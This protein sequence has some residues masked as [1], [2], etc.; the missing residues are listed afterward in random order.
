MI[1]TV[2]KYGVT[3]QE[4]VKR[5][6][7]QSTEKASLLHLLSEEKYS[8]LYLAFVK[9][10]LK[11]AILAWENKFH[12][13]YLKFQLLLDSDRAYTNIGSQLLNILDHLDHNKRGYKTSLLETE[14]K[15]IQLYRE[16][17]FT[18]LRKTFMPSLHLHKS[19]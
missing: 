16:H 11:G 17:H 13:Q 3:D 12:P 18:S 7:N 1:I 19:G 14:G 5:L 10:K 6:I 15:L 2:K 4:Q 9:E 8:F